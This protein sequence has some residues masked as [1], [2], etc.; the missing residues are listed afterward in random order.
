MV[1]Q[2]NKKV[3]LFVLL[4][5]GFLSILNQTLLNVALSE[6][7]EIFD[8]S[9]TTVQWLATGF[10]LVNGVLIPVTAFLMKRFFQHVNYLLARCYYCFWFYFFVRL[11]Q[12]FSV[13]LIGRMIQAAGAGIIMPLM[14]SVAMFIFPPEKKRKR[15]GSIRAS[16]DFRTCNSTNIIWFRD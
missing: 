10:M 2:I 5:G 3:L 13:L 7:M 4:L 16:N 11:Q 15:N 9:P 6:F 8:V 14:M 1:Q 12:I